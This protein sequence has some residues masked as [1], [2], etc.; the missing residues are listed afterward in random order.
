MAAHSTYVLGRR[1][2]RLCLAHNFAYLAAWPSTAWCGAAGRQ[3]AHRRYRPKAGPDDVLV[4]MT[5][6]PYRSE[7]VDAVRYS[8]RDRRCRH[9]RASPTAAASPIA[10][11]ADHVFV[12][13]TET[14]QFFTSAVAAAALL[15]A[16]MAFVNCRGR[17]GGHRQHRAV[18]PEAP[19]PGRLL[20][21]EGSET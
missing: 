16:L 21:K 2:P 15:E 14:P 6:E 7:V 20:G 9:H 12:V 19:P 10:L 17:R 1:H 4:A 13:P 11:A 5:F 8:A 3:P 18:P